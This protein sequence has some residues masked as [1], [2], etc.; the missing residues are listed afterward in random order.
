ML[1]WVVK[2]PNRCSEC[3]RPFTDPVEHHQTF[4][5]PS[6]FVTIGGR[7]VEIE[8]VESGEF[9][10]PWC[11]ESYLMAGPFKVHCTYRCGG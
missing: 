4:H 8:R 3:Y 9:L 1:W 11:V 6:I 5:V 7:D 2:D 10:C